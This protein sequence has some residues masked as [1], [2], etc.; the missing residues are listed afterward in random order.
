MMHIPKVGMGELA[1][2]GGDKVLHFCLYFLLAWLGGKAVAWRSGR[3]RLS[4]LVLWSLIYIVYGGLDEW[5][6]QYVGR[7]TSLHD[8]LADSAGVASAAVLLWFTSRGSVRE[9]R[10]S[11]S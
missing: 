3:L 5:T 2:K 7:T 1:I 8:W 4:H 6:Q 11:E 10:H 9:A